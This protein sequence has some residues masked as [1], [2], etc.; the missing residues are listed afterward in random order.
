MGFSRSPMQHRRIYKVVGR[1]WRNISKSKLKQGIS[2]LHRS[3]L[4]K[5]KA[6]PD[7]SFT[8]VLSDKGRMKAL[9]YHFDQIKIKTE[10]WDKK[11]RMVFFDIPEKFRW[12]RDSL[13]RKLR[14][15][16]FYELQK[17]FFVL[18]HECKDEIDFILEY[19]G[20]Q[21]YVRYAVVD[22]IDNETHLKE[23]F[24]LNLK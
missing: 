14:E 8:F 3:K 16:G 19:Y 13:R 7:G 20:I 10:N 9:T 5:E 17:S 6:N 12:G 2:Q 23:K 21:K 24:I 18:P 1:E 15:L 11:W 4:V 22:S